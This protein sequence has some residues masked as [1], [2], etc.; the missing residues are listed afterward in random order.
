MSVILDVAIHLNVESQ[1]LAKGNF[2]QPRIDRYFMSYHDNRRVAAI[3]SKRL[4]SAVEDLASGSTEV[5]YCCFLLPVFCFNE[6]LA[7]F[8]YIVSAN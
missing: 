7:G 3:K 5:G 4:R 8:R 6:Y 2:S 1:E